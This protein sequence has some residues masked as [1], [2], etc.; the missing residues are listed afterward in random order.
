MATRLRATPTNSTTTGAGAE[1]AEHRL[2]VQRRSCNATDSS[3]RQPS[4]AFAP[5]CSFLCAC[6]G[7]AFAPSCSFLCA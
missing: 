7:A 1:G 4:A 3:T 2:N 6:P 5:Y